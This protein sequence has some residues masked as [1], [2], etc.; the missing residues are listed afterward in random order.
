MG[1]MDTLTVVVIVVAVGVAA[2]LAGVEVARR[3]LA[4]APVSGSPRRVGARRVALALVEL[5]AQAAGERDAACTLP[6]SRPR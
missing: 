6:S 1:G 5:R 2:A 3:R 4:A